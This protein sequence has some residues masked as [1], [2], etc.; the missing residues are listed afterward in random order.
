MPSV[1]TKFIKDEEGKDIRCPKNEKLLRNLPECGVFDYNLLPFR[2]VIPPEPQKFEPFKFN[3]KDFSAPKRPRFNPNF[4]EPDLVGTDPVYDDRSFPTRRLKQDD[5]GQAYIR[6][7]ANLGEQLNSL[8]LNQTLDPQ[9]LAS[10]ITRSLEL[11]VDNPAFYRAGLQYGDVLVDDP[12]IN[13]VDVLVDAPRDE[14]ELSDFNR[15]VEPERIPQIRQE[16][17]PQI[18]TDPRD[19]EFSETRFRQK[20]I[21][22]KDNYRIRRLVKGKDPVKTIELEPTSPSQIMSPEEIDSQLQAAP[23]GRPFDSPEQEVDAI[24]RLAGKKTRRGRPTISK[25]DAEEIIRRLAPRGTTRERVYEVLEENNLIDLEFERSIEDLPSSERAFARRTRA[26]RIIDALPPRETELTNLKPTRVPTTDSEGFTDVLPQEP[27]LRRRFSPLDLEA[28]EEGRF[29]GDTTEEDKYSVRPSNRNYKQEIRLNAIKAKAK[30]KEASIK[31][32]EYRKNLMKEIDSSLLKLKTN[33]SAQFKS[34]YE[35]LVDTTSMNETELIDLKGRLEHLSLGED[36][37]IDVPDK[38]FTRPI[39][40]EQ[41]TLDFDPLDEVQDLPIT[42]ARGTL[43]KLS[44]KQRIAVARGSLS[45]IP[46]IKGASAATASGVGILAGYGI[47]KL[48]NDAGV[49]PYA[50]AALSGGLGDSAARISGLVGEQVYT[51]LA[52]RGL[53]S[54]AATAFQESAGQV[55]LRAG[56]SLLRGGLEGAGIGLL[57]MPLDMLMN[58]ALVKSGMSHAGANVLSS[59][60]VGVGTTA[61]IGA[62]SLAA[63]PETL[64][65][66]LLVGGVATGISALIS[67]FTG[68]AEDQQR[69]EQSVA[70]RKAIQDK[71]FARQVF[72]KMLPLNNYDVDKTLAKMNKDDIINY[73]LMA[74]YEPSFQ[75]LY[76]QMKNVLQLKP[77][78]IPNIPPTP[79]QTEDEKR[80]N[81][82]FSQAVQ[83]GLIKQICSYSTGTCNPELT[84]KDP[85]DITRADKD[86]LNTFSNFTWQSYVEELVEKSFVETQYTGQ[87]IKNAQQYLI[88]QWNNNKKPD[89]WLD[90][91]Y[92]KLAFQDPEF[93]SKYFEAIKLDAQRVVVKAFYDNQTKLDDLP[94]EIRYAAELDADFKPTITAFYGAMN[95]AANNL[96]ISLKQLINIQSLPEQQQAQEYQRIQFDTIKTQQKVVQEA[97]KLAVEQDRVRKVGYYDIDAGFLDTSDPTSIS[98]WK[99]SDSQ[100]LQ[101]NSAGMNLNEYVAYIH[102]LALG[103]AGD[104]TKLPTYSPQQ[105]LDLKRID[106]THFIDEIQTAGY[107]PDLYIF[108]NKTGKI[109]LNPN[110]SNIPDLTKDYKSQ[111]TSP[112]DEKLASQYN[113][114]IQGL[115]EKQQEFINN[116]N[117][118]LRRHLSVYGENYD[119]MVAD[120]NDYIARTARHDT[121]LLIF[122]KQEFME[123]NSLNYHPI[124]IDNT[125]K[126]ITPPATQDD[127]D[128]TYE[129]GGKFY[130]RAGQEVDMMTGEVIQP[131]QPQ[132]TIATDAA[133]VQEPQADITNMP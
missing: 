105:D 124:K 69:Q 8:R 90:P 14:I 75:E 34:G 2:P 10:A 52:A 12:D 33:L 85:G 92:D 104:Y 98:H 108:D 23:S 56:T 27:T 97:G 76:K 101:A 72:L 60:A 37:N 70:S 121:H 71:L 19:S 116:Y 9:S 66:S 102:Q 28:A 36:M 25:R 115:N 83:H 20:P 88:D 29:L 128:E 58:N 18:I 94:P 59:T 117:D 84:N 86:F 46:T 43:P 48:L 55:A 96:N 22:S 65:L 123:K 24:L 91:I 63:A 132:I 118:N 113:N 89:M 107:S 62:V 17:L 26:M 4:P 51:R 38:P 103:Q 44:F 7:R 49:D 133:Q 47:S 129:S 64:G 80:A 120:Q 68:Q 87:R 131:T 41:G 32:N 82:L 126:N 57:T 35:K 111:F 67:F 79:N 99:P 114:L 119:D 5:H 130:N 74:V 127:G 53:T 106:Y 54:A 109:T 81:Q 21:E 50:N 100:I 1:K 11:N 40:I 112:Y 122:D 95:K 45:D 16:R 61:A 42:G 78:T 125:T 93:E 15:A 3:L 6:G 73:N 39:D 30:F 110:A 31:A 77:G 13:L